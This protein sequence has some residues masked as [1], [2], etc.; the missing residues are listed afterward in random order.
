M[1]GDTV[2]SRNALQFTN[3]NKFAYAYSGIVNVT[4]AQTTLLEFFTNSSYLV[5]KFQPQYHQETTGNNSRFTVLFDDVIVSSCQMTSSF[6]YSPFEEIEL[7]IPPLTNVKIIA[8]NVS[9]GT[10]DLLA[11]ITG[12]VGMPQRVGN[13]DE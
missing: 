3:D 12:K 5:A 6:D 10:T 7:I 13:L 4:T 1:S 2:I 11:N 9:S 8:Q